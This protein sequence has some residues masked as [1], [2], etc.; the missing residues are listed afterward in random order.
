VVYR[1]ITPSAWDEETGAMKYRYIR[2]GADHYSLAFTY[3][4]LASERDRRTGPPVV[5]FS[6]G[7]R[8]SSWP[9]GFD[10]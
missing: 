6:V 2:T 9:L 1:K 3:A 4:L 7:P 10:R 5:F 8:Y